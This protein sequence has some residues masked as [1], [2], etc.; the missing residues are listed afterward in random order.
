MVGEQLQFARQRVGATILMDRSGIGIL[1][2]AH[3]GHGHDA[4]SEVGEGHGGVVVLAPVEP[5]H[6]GRL[7]VTL[8]LL[9]VKLSDEILRGRTA[10]DETWV[11]VDD[12]DILLVGWVA[13]DGQREE[14]G[15]LKLVG[16]GSEALTPLAYV[17]PLLEIL[18]LIEAHVLIGRHDHVPRL[19]G[20]IPEDLRVAEV[21]QS[22]K[23]RHHGVALILD[24]GASV[25][26]AVSHTLHLHLLAV[27]HAVG[28]VV[29]DDCVLAES[30]RVARIDDGASR[31]DVSHR[32]AGD[33]GVEMIPVYEVAA[34]GV[35]PVHVAPLRSVGVVLEVEMILPILVGESVGVVHPSVERRV[36]IDGAVV[37]RIG[38]VEGVR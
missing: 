37:V 33:G 23:R 6:G 17:G 38:R 18:R 11:D 27:S 15:T 22:V 32:V 24:E 35:A 7:R 14:V 1:P 3:P 13:I 10:K 31:E 29:G 28:S 25:V 12:H 34:D 19:R 26:L 20:L 2:V 5:F 4:V 21:L 9:A 8:E 36:V 16:L 30:C